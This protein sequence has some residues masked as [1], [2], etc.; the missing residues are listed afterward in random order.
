MQLVTKEL[1]RTSGA[2]YPRHSQPGPGAHDPLALTCFVQKIYTAT[3]HR[4]FFGSLDCKIVWRRTVP[5]AAEL[6]PDT[7][8]P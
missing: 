6:I 7:G 1:K 5:D 3:R 8:F 4:G 2:L